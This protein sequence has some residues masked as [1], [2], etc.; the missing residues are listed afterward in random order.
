MISGLLVVRY[1]KLPII[2]Q[3]LV[4]STDSHSSSF[5]SLVSKDMESKDEVKFDH[6]A[7]F[8]LVMHDLGKFITHVLTSRTEYDVI[9]IYW[10]DDEALEQRA[11]SLSDPE[12]LDESDEAYAIITAAPSNSA[13]SSKAKVSTLPNVDSLSNAVIY[14]FLASQSNGP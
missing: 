6:H 9:D 14:S 8:E 11:T 5:V 2:P 1:N 10:N 12:E 3:Y 13:A 4:L 7:Y